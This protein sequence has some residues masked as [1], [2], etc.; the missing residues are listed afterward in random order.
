MTDDTI[1]AISTP[2]GEGG[3]AVIRISGAAALAIA[4]R[5]FVAPAGKAGTLS[6]APSHTLHFGHVVRDGEKI[7]EV[8][9][10]VMRAPRTF[11][12]EDI[13]EFTCHGG[14]LPVKLVLD[15]V[16]A[17]GARLAEPGEFTRRAFLNGRIDLA[18]AEAIADVIHSRTELALRAANE[19]LAGKLSKRIEE[20]REQLMQTLAHIE[21]HIDFPDED[22]APDTKDQL[23]ERMDRGVRFMDRLLATANEGQILRRGVRAAIVG[24]PNAG[25]SS[26]LNQ[27]LGRDRAIVSPIPGT[28]RD[29]IEET[30]NVRGLPIVFVD[31]A[32]LREA[33]DQIELEGMRRSRESLE[34]AELILHVLDRSEPLTEA[35]TR[36]LGELAGRKRIIVRNKADLPARLEASLLPDAPVVD[37]SCLTGDGI[38]TLKDRIRELVWSGGVG[39]EMLE[40]MI[41]SRH[42][43]ALNRARAAVVRAIDA[44]RSDESL[45]LVA[46][47]LR[48]GV[49]AVGEI[50]GK[51]AT[52]DLLDMIFSRFCIGK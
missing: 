49:N 11:T 45:E 27:L 43:D 34:R 17:A 25:K 4:D 22:I 14:I 5:C 39:T 48:I 19:Q 36:H 33:G 6:A 35:D 1:A 15:A 50:V 7:D 29:T 37:V 31:T 42:Q 10:A 16:L 20:V 30:A 13:V 44:L 41:N 23:L 18:Q 28:T 12:R 21:A 47:D 24:R 32:G 9:A 2:I 51:T 26:L 8:L 46:M 40:V 3:L 38:E 52:D